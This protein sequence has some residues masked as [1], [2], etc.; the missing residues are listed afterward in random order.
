MAAHNLP[1]V[2]GRMRCADG[3]NLQHGS[4]PLWLEARRAQSET[5]L[6]TVGTAISTLQREACLTGTRKVHSSLSACWHD[7]AVEIITSWQQQAAYVYPFE[8]DT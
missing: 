3:T 5:F 8:R 6:G 1:P 2:A 7:L 4:S